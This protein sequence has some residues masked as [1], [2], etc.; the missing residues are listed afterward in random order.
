M[1]WKPGYNFPGRALRQCPGLARIG[2]HYGTMACHGMEE[3][4]SG[5]FD[6]CHGEGLAAI[7]PAWMKNIQP[8]RKERNLMFA[9]NVFGRTDV[10][11][12]RAF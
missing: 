5:R 3:A 4:M 6:I 9:R 11:G 8:V 1:I 7:F 10:D 2:D 12:T